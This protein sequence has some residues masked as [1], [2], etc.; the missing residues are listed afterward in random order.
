MRLFR[1]HDL[2]HLFGKMNCWDPLRDGGRPQSVILNLLL[3]KSLFHY[4][5]FFL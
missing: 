4:C 1:V 5:Y 3:F 2:W